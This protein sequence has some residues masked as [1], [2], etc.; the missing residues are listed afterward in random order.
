MVFTSPNI[1]VYGNY[2]KEEMYLNDKSISKINDLN[3]KYFCRE[4]ILIK[5]NTVNFKQIN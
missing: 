1:I 5:K 2:Q 3:K 4:N